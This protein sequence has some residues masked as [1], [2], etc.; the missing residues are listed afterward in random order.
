MPGVPERKPPGAN[1]YPEDMTREEFEAWVK[2]LSPRRPR[3]G[4]RLLHRDPP[5]ARS[6]HLTIVPYSK[7]YAADLAKAAGLLREAAALTDNASLKNF[8]TSARRC[9]PLQRLLRQRRRLDGSG[10]AA[11]HHHRAVRNLQRRTVRLQGRLR[12]VRQHPRRRKETDQLEDSSPTICRRWRT[13]CRSTRSIA[14]PSSARSAPIRVVNEVYRG[15]RWRARRPHRRLQPAQ[16][17]ARG[18]SRRAAS[19]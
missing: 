2:T 12:S 9:V 6:K 4:R 11:R 17:R 16:R 8:L 18:A 1:F 13:T 10:R 15:G 14:I 5:R 3:A 19:A 7:A